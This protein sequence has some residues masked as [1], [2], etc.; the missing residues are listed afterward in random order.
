MLSVLIVASFLFPNVA[1]ATPENQ[2]SILYNNR[3]FNV[4]DLSNE[5]LRWLNW[6]NSLPADLKETISYEPTELREL[7]SPESQLWFRS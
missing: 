7:F 4:S 2:E 5:T 6:Y 3:V 1:I